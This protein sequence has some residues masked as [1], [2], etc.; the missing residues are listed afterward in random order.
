MADPL[1]I[2]AG[3]IA[4][5][6]ATIQSSTA[7]YHTIE[8]FKNYPQRVRELLKQILSLTKILESLRELSEQDESVGAPL[9]VPLREC[10]AACARFKTVLELHRGSLSNGKSFAT[11]IS[12]RFR[13][14]DIVNFMETLAVYKSTMAIAIADAN[15]YVL[16]CPHLAS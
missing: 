1:S 16:P 15:L 12:F 7:L 11:W 8:S 2:A 4:V 3:I 5:I 14:G 6:T 13:N 9:E 10:G